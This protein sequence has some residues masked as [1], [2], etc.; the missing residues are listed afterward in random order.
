MQFVYQFSF[1]STFCLYRPIYTYDTR[2]KE[3]QAAR[4]WANT[5]ALGN[6]N[7]NYNNHNNNNYNN[8]NINIK[9][10]NK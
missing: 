10:N 2:G 6:N 8:Q 7:Y 3:D 1:S 5:S 9:N 4:H